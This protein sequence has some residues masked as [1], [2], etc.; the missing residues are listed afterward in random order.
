MLD[1]LTEPQYLALK[2]QERKVTLPEARRPISLRYH[3]F[4]SM[5]QKPQGNFMKKHETRAANALEFQGIKL[6]F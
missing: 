2:L 4:Q 6:E 3:V 1:A 5:T